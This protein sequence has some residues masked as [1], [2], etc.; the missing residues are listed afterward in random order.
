MRNVSLC[1][2]SWFVLQGFGGGA[3]AAE[4][5]VQ[6][7]SGEL[8]EV[9]VTGQRDRT[10]TKSGV[11]L[12]RTPQNIQV[13]SGALMRDQN[14]SLLEDALRNVAGV[15]PS[16]YATGFDFFRIRGFDASDFAYLDGLVRETSANIE[17]TGLDSVEVLKGPSSSLYG[18]GSPGGLVNLISKRPRRERFFD[19][20]LATGTD[21]Y[22]KPAV[23]FGG[24]LDSQGDVYGRLFAV[25][26]REG[27]FVDHVK[28]IERVYVAPSLT[29]EM[30]G[31]TTIT[32]LTRYQ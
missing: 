28:G 9:I 5:V 10:A 23:D 15:Q 4:P 27:S 32:F 17:L 18:Q 22:F 12:M 3:F 19:L 8:S 6:E 2:A 30:S 21:S 25:Y 31:N 14:T 7:D 13:L 1:A 16:G 11:D 26:R 20:E 24:A 29:W